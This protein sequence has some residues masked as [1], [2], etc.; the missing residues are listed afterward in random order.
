[1]LTESVT[2]RRINERI[3]HDLITHKLSLLAFSCISFLFLFQFINA[4][5]YLEKL[6]SALV[7]NPYCGLL[8]FIKYIANNFLFSQDL[9]IWEVEF[10]EKRRNRKVFHLLVHPPG[11]YSG[12]SWIWLKPGAISFFWVSLIRAWAEQLELTS[13]ASPGHN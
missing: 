4:W 13:T 12:R 9:F 11:G 7:N 8:S 3:T 1:M 5:V 6:N 10:I 2:T